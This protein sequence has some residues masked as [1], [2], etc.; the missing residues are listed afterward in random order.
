[1]L[2]EKKESNTREWGSREEER[3]IREKEWERE[4]EKKF[5]VCALFLVVQNN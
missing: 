4:E 3:K 1:M 2:K 5:G